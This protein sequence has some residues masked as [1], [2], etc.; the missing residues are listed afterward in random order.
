[1]FGRH[2]Q[3]KIAKD[4]TSTTTYSVP[5]LTK[6]DIKEMTRD[7]VKYVSGGIIAV[8]VVATALDTTSQVIVNKTAPKED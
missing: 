2:V 6:T 7:V 3:V 1:M 5:K 8:M 4:D